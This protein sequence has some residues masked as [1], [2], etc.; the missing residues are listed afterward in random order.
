[1]P[2]K[3]YNIG[4]IYNIGDMLMTGDDYSGTQDLILGM[5]IDKYIDSHGAVHVVE[6]YTQAWPVEDRIEHLRTLNLLRH[7]RGAYLAEVHKIYAG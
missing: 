4:D 2:A 3:N 1:M 7:Y 6:W 5:I